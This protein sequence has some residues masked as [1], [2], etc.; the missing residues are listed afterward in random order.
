MDDLYKEEILEESAS[1]RNFSSLRVDGVTIKNP[2][3]GDEISLSLTLSGEGVV[4]D[5]VFSGHM[6][7]LAKASAS[8]FTEYSK[9]KSLE[10][11]IC[12]ED[13][14]FWDIAHSPKNLMRKNCIF[15]IKEG[16]NLYAKTKK[17][18]NTK[19]G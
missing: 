4:T 12:L 15:L 2:L 8:F 17:H 13:E 16:Y 6:C 3:C 5:V 14:D 7:A 1:P 18:Y 9:G 19:R 11:L 10:K